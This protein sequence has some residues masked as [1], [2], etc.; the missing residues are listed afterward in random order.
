M[1]EFGQERPKAKAVPKMTTVIVRTAVAAVVGLGVL[2][3]SVVRI[4]DMGEIPLTS[5]V[6]PAVGLFL[7]VLAVLSARQY[8]AARALDTEGEI[9]EGRVV[10]LR[11]RSD[12]D[13][14]RTCYVTYEFGEGYGAEQ[15]VSQAIF[16]RL[17]FGD[18]VEIRY[19]PSNPGKSRMET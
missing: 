8:P 14:D 11:T 19:L 17:S 10:G 4:L 13:G 12:S 1:G 5:L 18:A 2:A 7:L 3:V 6:M 9:V 15:Q 16:R